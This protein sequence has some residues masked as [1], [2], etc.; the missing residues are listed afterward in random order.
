M[1]FTLNRF[2]HPYRPA[3]VFHS[4]VGECSLWGTEW[5]L[6]SEKSHYPR[7]PRSGKVCVSPSLHNHVSSPFPQCSLHP[8]FK[9]VVQGITLIRQTRSRIFHPQNPMRSTA[10]THGRSSKDVWRHKLTLVTA[11][12]ISHQKQSFC[13]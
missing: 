9:G 2:W 1:F 12:G 5:L 3:A 13:L 6:L 11:L 7:V 10:L 8:A 4:V